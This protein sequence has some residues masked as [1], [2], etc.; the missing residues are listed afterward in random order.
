MCIVTDTR[1]QADLTASKDGC[2]WLTAKS[3]EVRQKAAAKRAQRELAMT[4]K[5]VDTDLIPP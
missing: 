1:C 5:I 2:E 3:E 4:P